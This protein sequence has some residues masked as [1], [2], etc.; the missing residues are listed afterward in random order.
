MVAPIL[1]T[2]IWKKTIISY[3]TAQQFLIKYFIDRGVS[4]PVKINDICP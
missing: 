2:V 3:A 1:I 4:N